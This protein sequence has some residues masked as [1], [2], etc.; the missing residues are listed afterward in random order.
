MAAVARAK[1][2]SLDVFT[3]ERGPQRDFNRTGLP[4]RSHI[5]VIV[6][7]RRSRKRFLLRNGLTSRLTH[8]A[9][10]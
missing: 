10:D 6:G 3:S 9:R 4:G 8:A 2:R 7:P 1:S 5:L